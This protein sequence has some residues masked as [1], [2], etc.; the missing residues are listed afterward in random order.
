MLCLVAQSCLTPGTPWTVA[1]QILCP[2]GFFRQEYWSGCHACPPGNHPNPG[3]ESRS[4]A[5]QE[6][7][8]PAELPGKAVSYNWA[9]LVA[10]W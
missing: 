6:D 10:Q 2:W 5:L 4:P 7:S 8:L 3:T 1:P 9:S